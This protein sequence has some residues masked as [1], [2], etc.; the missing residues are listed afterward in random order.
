MTTQTCARCGGPRGTTYI[1]TATTPDEWTHLFEDDC[2]QH[3][4]TRAEAAES[5]SAR[6][7]AER[8]RFAELAKGNPYGQA[9]LSLLEKLGVAYYRGYADADEANAADRQILAN[10]AVELQVSL[11]DSRGSADVLS[12]LEDLM[13]TQEEEE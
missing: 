4:R 11:D 6:L 3:L 5:E 12:E 1:S 10:R 13:W 7:T 9:S 2:I 8:E